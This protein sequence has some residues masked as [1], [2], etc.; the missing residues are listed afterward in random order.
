VQLFIWDD[1]TPGEE[2]QWVPFWTNDYQ[3][4]GVWV[5]ASGLFPARCQVPIFRIDEGYFMSG[6]DYRIAATFRT[7]RHG[8][9]QAAV[10]PEQYE[11]R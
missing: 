11:P 4:N 9:D 2:P 3:A 5:P 6:Y 1:I 7:S 8:F 10:L